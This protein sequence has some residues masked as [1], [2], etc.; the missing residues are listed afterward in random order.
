[1]SR[2]LAAAVGIAVLTLSVPAYAHVAVTAPGATR[3]GDAVFTVRV[4]TESDTLSTTGL[5]LQ[6][7]TDT[8]IASVTVK[9]HAG[10]SFITKTVKLAK[11]I[12]TDDGPVSEA[13]GEVDWKADSAASA[14]KPGEFDEFELSA[15][16]LP[17]VATLTFKAIQTYSDGSQ[18][19]WIE[20]AAP[21][22]TTQPEHPAPVVSLA[23]AVSGSDA[24]AGTPKSS[25]GGSDTAART[26]S[27]VALA[28][29]AV[30]VGLGVVQ[31]AKGRAEQRGS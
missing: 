25:G 3:G 29:A 16:P 12:T 7:P 13:V 28:L 8:P 17:D 11:P 6:L 22:S 9:P 30:A 1:M 18:V 15:G 5:Q 21:G 4:P 23:P 20:T 27:I 24:S 31:R 2:L 14:I 10:W 19:K 26:L